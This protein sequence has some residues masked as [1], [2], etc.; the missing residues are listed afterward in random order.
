MRVVKYVFN[1]K[2]GD[3]F[4]IVPLGDVHLGHRNAD[5]DLFEEVLKI[6]K[7]TEN[8]FWLGMGDY[9]DSITL[10]DDRYNMDSVDMRFIT[11]DKQ[12]RKI[13]EYFEPI[14]SKCLG[15][16]DGNHEITYWEKYNHNYVDMLAYDLGITYLTIDAYIRLVFSRNEGKKPKRYQFNIYAHHGYTSA[17][18]KGAKVNRIQDLS[19][20]FPGIQLYL[21]GHTHELGPIPP[22]ITLKV[23]NKMNV[24]DQE[25]NFVSTGGY[26]RGY[27]DQ[28]YSYIEKKILVPTAL[29]SPLITIKVDDHYKRCTPFRIN[30]TKIP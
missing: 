17:R 24:R 8:C 30:I 20:I 29:G 14:K 19:L 2:C 15:L 12:F 9:C 13:K 11:P 7:N 26:L 22:T 28:S 21:M 10:K 18:T 1:F 3:V 25:I 27:V 4:N 5:L 23:D 6:I 16:L